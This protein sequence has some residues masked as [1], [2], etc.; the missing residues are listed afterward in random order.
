MLNFL[1]ENSYHIVKCLL[2]Q[3]A[4]TLFGLMVA[5][6]TL[7]NETL[8]LIGSLC[9]VLLYLV[10]TYYM[11]WEMG[12]KDLIHEESGRRR[13]TPLRG[14]LVA[15]TASIPNIILGVLVVA[16][17]SAAL[18]SEAAGNIQFVANLLARGLEAMYLGLIVLYS[19]NNP[20]A[21]LLIVLPLLFVA[22]FAYYLGHRNFRIG[23]LF[24]IK[25]NTKNET[26]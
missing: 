4:M 26:R 11:F 10:I 1:K 15:L 22:G 3:I 23:S 6:A 7:Q 24:G 5:F 19:P 8:L 14:L 20:I 13:P 21:F 18:T 9:A 12:G 2:N 16:T 17:K 25:A